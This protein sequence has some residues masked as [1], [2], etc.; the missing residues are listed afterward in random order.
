MADGQPRYLSDREISIAGDEVWKSPASG[1]DYPQRWAV[2]IAGLSP[3]QVRSEMPGQELMTNGSTKV[4]YFEGASD[5]LDPKGKVVGRGY[6]EM[7]GY[8]PKNE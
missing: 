8:T 1:A 5:I 4:T 3:L 2:S 6:L 7:T